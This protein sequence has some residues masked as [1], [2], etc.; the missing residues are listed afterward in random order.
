MT[1]STEFS[2][3]GGSL[4]YFNGNVV[5]GG[6]YSG[7]GRTGL[8]SLGSTGWFSLIDLPVLVF[9]TVKIVLKLVEAFD[10]AR[11]LLV[12][13]KI[14]YCLE[15]MLMIGRQQKFIG[16]EKASIMLIDGL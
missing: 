14:C 8:E 7:Q 4:G 13:I 16:S 1:F 6:A 2:H 3:R 15:E 10:E 11:F 9:V 12:S 5:A